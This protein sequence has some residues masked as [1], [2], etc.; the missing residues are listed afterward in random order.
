MGEERATRPL[1]L[2]IGGG[3]G[4]GKTTLAAILSEHLAMPVNQADDFRLF[5]QRITSPAEQ[6]ALHYFVDP[7]G[8]LARLTATPGQ[9]LER[10]I[11]IAELV[12][13]GLEVVIAHHLATGRPLILEGDSIAPGLA[14]HNAHAGSPA[15]GRV[16]AAFLHEPDE[17]AILA[18][19]R[20]RGRGIERLSPI[21]QERGARVAWLYG[22]WIAEQAARAGLPVV[23]AR[24]HATLEQ[25]VLAALA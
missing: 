14:L 10:L 16:G 17:A 5:G 19:M 24:P 13:H 25:R 9:L 18:G 3:S 4:T 1:V 20:S 2:L 6:P 15:G 7:E 21:E 12:S 11:A 8:D 22:N 23:D